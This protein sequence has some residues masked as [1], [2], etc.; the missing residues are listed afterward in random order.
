MPVYRLR[1]FS[2]ISLEGP[3]GPVGG[4]VSQRRPL[5]LLSLLAVSPGGV[6]SRDKLLAYLWPEEDSEHARHLL[7]V[8]L[9]AVRQALGGEAVL[10]VG[11]DLRLNPDVVAADVAEFEAAVEAGELRRAVALYAG[12][13]LDGFHLKGALGFE[14]WADAEQER[15]ARLYA[16]ALEGLAEGAEADG[17]WRG[18]VEAWRKLAAHDPYS[19]RIALRLMQ[20]LEAAGDRPGALQHAQIHKTLVQEE[21]GVE[22]DPEVAALAGQLRVQPPETE[23]P[24][25]FREG[26]P[27]KDVGGGAGR[28]T[29]APIH[30]RGIPATPTATAKRRFGWRGAAAA[31]VVLVLSVVVGVVALRGPAEQPTDPPVPALD[32]KR[33]LVLPFVNQ[34]GDARLDRLGNMAADWITQGLAET[35]LVR[36]VPTTGIETAEGLGELGSPA[37]RARAL[38]EVTRAAIAVYGSFYLQ[39]D[40]LAFQAQVTDVA[41]GELLR[42]IGEITAPVERPKEA[43]ETLRQRTT[44]ALATVLDPLLSSWA[45]AASQPPSYEA[46]QLYADGMDAFFSHSLKVAAENF[47][48]A[49]ALDTTF[50]VPLL[51]ALYA[52]GNAGNRS[53]KD[54]LAHA[55]DERRDRLTR[56]ERALLDAH[57]ANLRGDLPGEYRAYSRVVELTPGSEWNYKLAWTANRLG[58]PREAVELLSQVDPERGWLAHWEAYWSQ[59]TQALHALGDYEQELQEARRGRLQLPES[60]WGLGETIALAALGR[61]DELWL[62][63]EREKGSL[64]GLVSSAT[65]LRFHGHDAEADRVLERA[66]ERYDQLPENEITPN[67]YYLAIPLAKAGRGD[68]ALRLLEVASAAL[69]ARGRDEHPFFLASWGAI[70]AIREDTLEARAYYERLEEYQEAGLGLRFQAAI[71]A[72]LG[73]KDLAVRLLGRAQAKGADIHRGGHGVFFEPLWNYAPFLEL[74]RPKG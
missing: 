51:W 4:R 24:A 6:L 29:A 32:P 49:A 3:A 58:R 23:I 71:A 57:L 14:R 27:A 42:A 54:S 22:P 30:S 13:L 45:S 59:L 73:E 17:N 62:W 40:S 37:A 1:L 10:S 55:L 53:A 2:G 25:S 69:R 46:Y 12:P 21:L 48:R 60:R 8:T 63:I 33:V 70:A 65:E 16:G 18:A 52:H 31:T 20:A 74:M 5:A 66:F 15:L 7:S 26:A 36:A 68:D 19:S 56:W 9:H 43:V 47:H 28:D 39:D 61:T 35:G 44:G 50:S 41:T 38:A 72:H 67:D 64:L 34:T 11:D